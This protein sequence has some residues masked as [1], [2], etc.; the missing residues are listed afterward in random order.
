MMLLELALLHLQIKIKKE[1]SMNEKE[2]RR[3]DTRQELR[4]LLGESGM[5]GMPH[6]LKAAKD[7]TL[8]VGDSF[9]QR[10][11]AESVMLALAEV[12]GYKIRPSE[13]II[14]RKVCTELHD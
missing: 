3:R 11:E 13:L 1:L 5:S 9:P 2:I 10:H 12:H 4:A 7:L 8:D 6:T 14:F